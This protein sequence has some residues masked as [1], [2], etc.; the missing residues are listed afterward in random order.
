LSPSRLQVV[1]LMVHWLVWKAPCTC[2]ISLAVR[3]RAPER[4][5]TRLTSSF[6]YIL[7]LSYRRSTCPVYD[8]PNAMT[9]FNFDQREQGGGG[10]LRS[11]A[12]LFFRVQA[13]SPGQPAM[14]R[15]PACLSSRRCELQRQSQCHS[16]AAPD[17]KRWCSSRAQPGPDPQS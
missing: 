11:D 6:L 2:S 4:A 16:S 5:R 7:L 14:R 12:A 1:W 10:S 9:L 13:V 15:S 3:L 8:C 17:V